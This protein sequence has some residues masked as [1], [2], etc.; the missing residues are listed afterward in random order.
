MAFNFG[1][2][3]GGISQGLSTG[4]NLADQMQLRKL[5]EAQ[6]NQFNANNLANQAYTNALIPGMAPM[7][8]GADQDRSNLNILRRMPLIDTLG[9]QLGLWG[10]IP[11]SQ[12]PL[13]QGA[14]PPAYGNAQ[15]LAPQQPSASQSAGQPAISPGVPGPQS[16]GLPADAATIAAAIDKA[17]PGLR[18][19]NPQAYAAAVKLGIEYAQQQAQFNLENAYKRASIEDIG[20]QTKMRQAQTEAIPEETAF[21]REQTATQKVET[22]IKQ[23]ELKLQPTKLDLEKAELELKN[24]QADAVQADLRL[25]EAENNLKAGNYQSEKEWRDAQMANLRAERMY[26]IQQQK[27]AVIKENSEATEREA[28]TRKENAQADWYE[29]RGTTPEDKDKVINEELT[30]A[31]V[32]FRFHNNEINRLLTSINPNDPQVKARI[33]EHQ[34][35]ATAYGARMKDLEGQLSTAPKP[36][37]PAEITPARQTELDKVAN[38]LVNLSKTNDVQGAQRLVQLMK[39]RG[40]PQNEIDWVLQRGRTLSQSAPTPAQVPMSR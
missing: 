7:P 24:R 15:Q 17:N 36:T 2:L 10:D 19:S 1:A 23:G 26:K 18:M 35:A 27:L 29:R 3:A 9:R 8:V 21:K 22:E 30:K 38:Q 31:G 16:S 13:H 14:Q 11:N 34:R 25:R 37:A 33:A 20:A 4:V 28:R 32:N 40:F 6:L 12:Y 39:D 5:R